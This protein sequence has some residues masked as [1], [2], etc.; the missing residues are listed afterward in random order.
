MVLTVIKTGVRCMSW[1]KSGGDLITDQ[2]VT[3]VKVA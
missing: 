2:T 1:D 3:G